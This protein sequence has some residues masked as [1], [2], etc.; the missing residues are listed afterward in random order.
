MR[1]HLA[2]GLAAGW[3]LALPLTATADAAAAD[4]GSVTLLRPAQV[5]TAGEPPHSGWVV[6]TR[7]PRI[8]A[9]GPAAS[10]QVVERWE[11]SA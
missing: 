4:S 7:G 3:A 10:V 9:V 5:W 11:A 8:V 2:C 6:V 1:A